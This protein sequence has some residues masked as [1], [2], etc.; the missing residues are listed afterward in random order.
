MTDREQYN[1]AAIRN[2]L[3]EAFTAQDLWRFCQERPAF[4]PVLLHFPFNAT[5]AQMIDALTEYCRTQVLFDELLAE[6]RI[7][8]P[9]QYERYRSL[10]Y[11]GGPLPGRQIPHNLPPRGEFVGR[12]KEKARTHAALCSRWP[13]ISIEGIGGIGKT[14]LA[15][16]VAYECLHASQIDDPPKGIVTFDSFVWATARDRELTLNALLDAIALTLDYPGIVQRPLEQKCIGVEKLLQDKPC[17]LIVDN[18]ETIGD[19]AIPGFLHYL[20]EPSKALITTRELKLSHAWTIPLKGLEQAEALALIRGEGRRLGLTSIEEASERTLLYLHEATGGAPLALK[21][22]IGQIKQR[23]QSLD[24]VL[25][26]LHEARGSVFEQVF[27]RSWSLLSADARQVIMVMPL[28]ASSASQEAIEATSNVSHFALDNA[29]GQLVE[30]SLVDVTDELALAR[31]RYNI[32]PLT[33]AFA[34]D[35]IQM[36]PETWK[37]AQ[38]RLADYLLAFTEKHGHFWHYEGFSHLEVEWPNIMKAIQ[39]CWEHQAAKMAIRMASNIRNFL[40]TCGYWNDAIALGQQVVEQATELEDWLSV[41]SWRLGMIGWVQRHRGDLESAKAHALWALN[42][43]EQLD[44]QSWTAYCKRTLGRIAQEQGDRE[45]A[46]ELL[47]AALSYYESAQ[48]AQM[49]V[50][51]TGNVAQLALERGDWAVAS[52]LSKSMLPV[53]L[54]HSQLESSGHLLDVL[55]GVAWIQGNLDQAKVHWEQAIEY[56][57][58]AGRR[59][60]IADISVKLA[61]AEAAAGQVQEARRI[62][63]GVMETYYRLDMH[64]KAGRVK[65][66][67]ADLSEGGTPS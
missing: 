40:V 66:L 48:D 45:L 15:L 7:A 26:A 32:H 47:R 2:L 16:E 49:I 11:G 30:M 9:R 12:E 33:R 65:D 59:D 37:G 19:E 3:R 21:W 23:G 10:L 24:A 55:G 67:L 4:Q 64:S 6:I 43:F 60:E 17:L 29:L 57:Q 25:R 31:Q 34:N 38:R 1:I 56:M 52:S 58:H 51:V 42:V 41:A 46:D 20:P 61:R 14:A 18:F 54:E 8:N 5:P 39:W 27:A 35:K 36:E 13:L 53:A 44:E 28:F 62:L 50:F 22:A 63:Y